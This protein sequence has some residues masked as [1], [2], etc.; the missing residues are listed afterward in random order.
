MTREA[1]NAQSEYYG[2]RYSKGLV[3][4]LIIQVHSLFSFYFLSGDND[5]LSNEHI[6]KA[7]IVILPVYTLL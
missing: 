3:H 7:R 2:L 1:L 6:F 5:Y 4:P